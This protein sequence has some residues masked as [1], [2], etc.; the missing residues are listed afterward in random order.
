MCRSVSDPAERAY[1]RVYALADTSPDAMVRA[2]GRRWG[3]EAAN[4]AS[5][6]LAGLAD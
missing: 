2:V 3:I 5:K 6:G 4:A 1:Y